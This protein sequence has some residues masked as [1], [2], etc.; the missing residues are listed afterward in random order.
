MAEGKIALVVDDEPMPRR[1]VSEFLK[2]FGFKV[3]QAANAEEAKALIKEHHPHLLVTDFYMPGMTGAQLVTNVRESG[4]HHVH[5]LGISG[6]AGDWDDPKSMR[7]FVEHHNTTYLAAPPMHFLEKPFR[8][9]AFK[10]KL[11]EM[12]VGKETT[13]WKGL[14]NETKPFPSKKS[15]SGKPGQ[16]KPI[17]QKSRP[18]PLKRFGHK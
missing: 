12:G 9:D 2:G 16:E 14:I 3:H 11:D 15:V 1:L 8:M 13:K 5:V 18:F 7:A 6:R 17:T 4:N 10:A